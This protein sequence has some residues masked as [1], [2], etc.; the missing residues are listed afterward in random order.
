MSRR[1]E[2]LYLFVV[3]EEFLLQNKGIWDVRFDKDNLFIIN[4]NAEWLPNDV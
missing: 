2:Y 4:D 1:H 3:S